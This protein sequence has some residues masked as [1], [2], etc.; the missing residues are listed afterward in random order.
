MATHV[1]PLNHRSVTVS[2][3]YRYFPLGI[4]QGK[5]LSCRSPCWSQ[6]LLS[7]LYSYPQKGSGA[8]IRNGATYETSLR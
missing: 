7:A 6:E 8:T 2:N 1:H 5:E 3:D 4:Y